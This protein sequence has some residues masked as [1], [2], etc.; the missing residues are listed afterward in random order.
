MIIQQLYHK[1]PEAFWV[2][3]ILN[4]RFYICAYFYRQLCDFIDA[5]EGV[6]ETILRHL[7][8]PVFQM[9]EL[10]RSS[11]ETLTKVETLL[12]KMKG[13]LHLKISYLKNKLLRHLKTTQV[14]ESF[15]TWDISSLPIEQK[16]AVYAEDVEL[17]LDVK[18]GQIVEDYQDKGGLQQ[19]AKATLDQNVIEEE[20][21]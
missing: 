7:K 9:K 18:L 20:R 5:T 2:K 1:T 13:E 17:F 8:L 12:E 6:L 3:I 14:H 16:A 10:E 19:W 4:L 21:C 11:W 15:Y